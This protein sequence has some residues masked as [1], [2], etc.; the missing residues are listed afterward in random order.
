MRIYEKSKCK[1]HG[2]EG[3]DSNIILEFWYS[4]PQ[5]VFTLKMVHLAFTVIVQVHA[6]ELDYTTVYEGKLLQ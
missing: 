4:H 1:M 2:L 6:K 3:T 5:Q